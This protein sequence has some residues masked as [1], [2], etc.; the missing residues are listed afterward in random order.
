MSEGSPLASEGSCR[1]WGWMRETGCVGRGG[2]GGVA[3][4]GSWREAGVAIDTNLTRAALLRGHVI[5]LH[6]AKPCSKETTVSLKN[7]CLQWDAEVKVPSPTPHPTPTPLSPTSPCLESLELSNVPSS[8]VKPA[9]RDQKR[10]LYLAPAA[11]ISASLISAIP[12]HSTSSFFLP[13]FFCK[14]K[15]VFEREG[16]VMEG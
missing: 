11:R 2:E 9:G 13:S 1:W 15:C 5:P 14:V 12:V 10:S 4:N 3:Q 7:L 8:S 16:G 6:E